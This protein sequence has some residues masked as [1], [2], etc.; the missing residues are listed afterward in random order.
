MTRNEAKPC[1]T[2]AMPGIPHQPG[3]ALSLPSQPSASSE[4]AAKELIKLFANT[5]KSF[6][7]LGFAMGKETENA[8]ATFLDQH[9]EALR[10]ENAALKAQVER[11]GAVVEWGK[12]AEESLSECNEGSHST[13]RANLFRAIAALSQEKK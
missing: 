11:M 8:I 1:S 4:E 7:H 10:A 6:G 2:C 13:I 12:M 3:C 5:I 9:T